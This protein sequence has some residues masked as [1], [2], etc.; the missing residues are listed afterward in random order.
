M[1]SL[2]L[3]LSTLCITLFHPPLI[4]L[5]RVKDIKDSA[6]DF[7]SNFLRNDILVIKFPIPRDYLTYYVC[8]GPNVLV[9][10]F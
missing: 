5:E 8:S 1:P 6:L 4:Y 7:V 3:V 10:E 2:I 9:L